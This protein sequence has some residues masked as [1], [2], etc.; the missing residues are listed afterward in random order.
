MGR[1]R[2]I[3]VKYRPKSFVNRFRVT[4]RKFLYFQ[5]RITKLGPKCYGCNERQTSCTQRGAQPRKGCP[6]CEF[7]IQYKIFLKELED[8]LRKVKGGTR[9]GMRKW[10]LK[11]M[12]TTVIEVASIT[13]TSKK[14]NPKWPVPLANLVSVYRG[15]DAKKQMIENYVAP[16]EGS[17]DGDD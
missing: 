1:F 16:T 8:E 17:D 10:P 13:S 11:L 7:T 5:K 4:A 3:G 2:C 6:D 14:T 9:K 12:L 15:E